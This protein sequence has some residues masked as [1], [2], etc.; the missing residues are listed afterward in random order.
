MPHESREQ[1][2]LVSRRVAVGC[3]SVVVVGMAALAGIALWALVTGRGIGVRGWIFI[4]CFVAILPFLIRLVRGAR[5]PRES[6]PDEG[7]TVVPGR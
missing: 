6:K 7:P 1:S 5:K 3:V 2:E 4:V